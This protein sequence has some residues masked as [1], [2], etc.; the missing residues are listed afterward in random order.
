MHEQFVQ[1]SRQY[2]DLVVLAGGHNLVALD[3]ITQRVRNHIESH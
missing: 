3:M 2:A 1:P